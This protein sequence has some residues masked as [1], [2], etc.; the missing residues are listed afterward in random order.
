MNAAQA[1]LAQADYISYRCVTQRRVNADSAIREFNSIYSLNAYKCPYISLCCKNHFFISCFDIHFNAVYA[2]VRCVC[3]NMQIL[4]Q[5][6]RPE[7]FNI[8]LFKLGEERILVLIRK[9]VEHS[10][11]APR[12]FWLQHAYTFR[13]NFTF[14][15]S[16][17]KS[18]F[19]STYFKAQQCNDHDQQSKIDTISLT[20]DLQLTKWTSNLVTCILCLPIPKRKSENNLFFRQLKHGKGVRQR[21][22][23]SVFPFRV[24]DPGWGISHGYA[25]KTFPGIFFGC[26]IYRAITYYNLL[27]FGRGI[28]LTD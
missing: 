8:S 1:V 20:K 4:F 16:R 23:K 15:N 22:E 12:V 7:L 24:N 10:L 25:L 2:I 9:K 19:G 13:C 21:H 27:S 14:F 11:K 26:V 18:C 28:F 3:Q 5:Q 6:L 17:T